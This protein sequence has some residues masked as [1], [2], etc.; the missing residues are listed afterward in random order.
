MGVSKNRGKSPKS[1][2]LIGFSIIFTIHFGVPIFLVQHPN[3]FGTLL[4]SANFPSRPATSVHWMSISIVARESQWSTEAVCGKSQSGSYLTLK[5][6]LFQA[7]GSKLVYN[8]YILLDTTIQFVLWWN[9][10]GFSG[11]TV[12]LQTCIRILIFDCNFNPHSH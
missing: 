3:G 10:P 4:R 1:S 6:C 7:H 9:S 12:R 5:P 2:I 8:Y 11:Q